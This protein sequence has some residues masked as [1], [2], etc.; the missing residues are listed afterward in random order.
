MVNITQLKPFSDP[1]DNLFDALW[2]PLLIERPRQAGA[3]IRIDVTETKDAYTV[4]A[5]LPGVKRDDIQ[6]NIADNQVSISAEVGKQRELKADEKVIGSERYYGNLYRSF[7]FA[8]DVDEAAAQA[9][10][11]D[12][13]LELTLPK[14]AVTKAKKLTIQ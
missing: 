5:E 10:Y 8:Q 13:V 9:R 7:T 14:K 3:Q 6:V 4:Q 1:F 2:R 12:G 11:S